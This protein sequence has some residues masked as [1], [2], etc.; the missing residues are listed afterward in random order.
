MTPAELNDAFAGYFQKEDYLYRHNMEQTRWIVFAIMKA[1]SLTANN[2]FLPVNKLQ[3]IAAFPWEKDVPI[4][5]NRQE[6]WDRGEFTPAAQ[7]LL[8]KL[9]KEWKKPTKKMTPEEEQRVF[10]K[11]S[12]N[13]TFKDKKVKA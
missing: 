1:Q 12:G 3:D 13:V 10:A 9:P 4:R 8:D 6:Y 7:K 2:K 11:M 5:V